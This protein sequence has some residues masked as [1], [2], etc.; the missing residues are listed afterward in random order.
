MACTSQQT[1]AQCAC[2]H[3][4]LSKVSSDFPARPGCVEAFF[5][6]R[7]P[8]DMATRTPMLIRQI[9]VHFTEADTSAVGCVDFTREGV[10]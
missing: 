7:V 9:G 6:L 2:F 10:K 8:R 1:C 3:S 5:S 4:D